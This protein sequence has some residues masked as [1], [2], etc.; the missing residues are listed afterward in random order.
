MFAFVAFISLLPQH[1]LLLTP[2]GHYKE[3]YILAPHLYTKVNNSN[4]IHNSSNQP[5]ILDF[6]SP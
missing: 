2:V 6:L 5:L 3:I 4:N 1:P